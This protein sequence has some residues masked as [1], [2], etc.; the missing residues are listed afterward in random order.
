[1]ANVS[2]VIVRIAYRE[3]NGKGYQGSKPGVQ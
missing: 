2:V 1:M 3:K